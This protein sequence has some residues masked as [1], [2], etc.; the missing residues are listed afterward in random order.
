VARAELL[1]LAFRVPRF[2]LSISHALSIWNIFRVE[3]EQLANNS[4]WRAVKQVDLDFT[5]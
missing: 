4:E 3:W 5:K 1:L 2:R